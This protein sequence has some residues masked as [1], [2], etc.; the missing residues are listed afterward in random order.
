MVLNCLLRLHCVVIVQSSLSV[1]LLLLLSD[2]LF[3]NFVLIGW[4]DCTL[5]VDLLLCLSLH[6][7]SL[8]LEVHDG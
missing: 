1:E 2:W 4:L 6:A 8:L 7:F 3:D 5:D